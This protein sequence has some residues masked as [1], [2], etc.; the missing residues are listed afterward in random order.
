M[1]IA[2][3]E[4]GLK[5]G[6]RQLASVTDTNLL[7][8]L[9]QRLDPKTPASPEALSDANRLHLQLVHSLLWGNERPGDG[10]LEAVDGFT[11]KHQALCRDLLD[12]IA[13]QRERI[14]PASG[15]YFPERTGVLELHARYTRE[16]IML[17]L[18]KGTL[19]ASFSHREGV[20]HLPER[21]VD[22]LFVTINKSASEFSPTTMYEDYAV[23]D[24][25]FHWQSQSGVGPDSRTGQ[26]YRR[27][28]EMGY[29]PMLFVRPGKRLENGL[30]TP[31][32]FCGPLRY[33][34]HEGSHPMSIVWRL[35][36]PMP[37]RI[38]RLSHR[39]AA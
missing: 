3:Y 11:K 27:H 25:L 5:Q 6:L 30:T 32:F 35:E 7:D 28:Q 10:S 1:D 2:P 38:F 20:L 37:T 21:R 31:F 23:T 14:V 33:L 9:E 8:T 16:Q 13:Y 22:A 18:G 15:R 26:R 17:A 12:V 29:V 34:R 19:E 24:S 36:H 4:K 39:E